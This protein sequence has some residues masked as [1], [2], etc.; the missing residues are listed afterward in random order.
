MVRH[1]LVQGTLAWNYHSTMNLWLFDCKY[2]LI[3]SFPALWS[4]E[5]GCKKKRELAGL[6]KLTTHEW[7]HII[8]VSSLTFQ[9]DQYECDRE[10]HIGLLRA[11]DRRTLLWPYP[12]E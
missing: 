4:M 8:P 9:I 6:F 3:Y 11:L 2:L 12:L 1:V 7:L 5:T 10:R